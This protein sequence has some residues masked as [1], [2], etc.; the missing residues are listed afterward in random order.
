MLNYVNLVLSPNAKVQTQFSKE[1]ERKLERD[2]NSQGYYFVT[3]DNKFM[4]K[5]ISKAEKDCLVEK[6]KSLYD[7]LKYDNTQS[8]VQKCYG[9]YEL[10]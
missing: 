6:L 9:L 5:M 3:D 7:H 8:I 10:S 4:V 1:L 2:G